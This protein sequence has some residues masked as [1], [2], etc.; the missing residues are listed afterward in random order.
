MCSNGR[1]RQST[2]G[3]LASMSLSYLGMQHGMYSDNLPQYLSPKTFRKDF[4]NLDVDVSTLKWM[5]KKQSLNLLR[6]F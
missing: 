6:V 3:S 5:L 1:H 4:G 2:A